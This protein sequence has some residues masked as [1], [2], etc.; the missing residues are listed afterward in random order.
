VTDTTL[1]RRH[2]LDSEVA[3]GRMGRVYRAHDEDLT[4]GLARRGHLP[5]TEAFALGAQVAAALELLAVV[6]VGARTP[7]RDTQ[8]HV[9]HE[10]Q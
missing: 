8:H 9:A 1:A 2:R 6:Q 4:S 10:Q 5:W 3:R 7:T